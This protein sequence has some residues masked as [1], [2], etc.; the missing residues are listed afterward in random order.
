MNN[1]PIIYSFS[2]R[3]TFACPSRVLFFSTSSMLHEQSVSHSGDNLILLPFWKEYEH[4]FRTYALWMSFFWHYLD[5]DSLRKCTISRLLY[6][7]LLFPFSLPFFHN[8]SLFRRL[9]LLHGI[10]ERMAM[11]LFLSS[12]MHIFFELEQCSIQ[13][14]S[15]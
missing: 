7:S 13:L 6:A 15:R 4:G 1:K 5:V 2:F 10:V 9:F 3:N 11:F 14:Q 8:Q 12:L